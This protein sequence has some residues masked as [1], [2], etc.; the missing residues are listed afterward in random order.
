MTPLAQLMKRALDGKE[1]PSRHETLCTNK[2]EVALPQQGRLQKNDG[3]PS[4]CLWQLAHGLFM[5]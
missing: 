3:T 1:A 5:C 4:Q 2:I